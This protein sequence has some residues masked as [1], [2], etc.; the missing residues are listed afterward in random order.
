MNRIYFVFAFV[1][2]ALSSATVSA[3]NW[4][5]QTRQ[6]MGHVIVSDYD[7]ALGAAH[8]ALEA[9]KQELGPKH[10]NTARAMNNLGWVYLQLDRLEDARM[11]LDQAIQIW[12][13]SP[14]FEH[15]DLAIALDNLARCHKRLGNDLWMIHLNR[16]TLEERSLSDSESYDN[17]ERVPEISL[18][19]QILGEVEA[20]PFTVAVRKA[21]LKGDDKQYEVGIQMCDLAY[22][23]MKH[24]QYEYAEQLLNKSEEVLEQTLGPNDSRN[25]RTI[26][27]LAGIRGKSGDLAATEQ[28]YVKALNILEQ[29]PSKDIDQVVQVHWGL[30]DLFRLTGQS[31]LTDYISD[32][33][34]LVADIEAGRKPKTTPL[35][36]VEIKM[37]RA[38]GTSRFDEP[39]IQMLVADEYLRQAVSADLLRDYVLAES[40]YRV[41]L[42]LRT[43]ALGPKH[44]Q[45][46]ETHRRIADLYMAV[47]LYGLAEVHY[48]RALAIRETVMEPNNPNLGLIK[49]SLA[50]L[51]MV[52]SQV[53]RVP[54]EEQQHIE[55][56]AKE[57]AP[58]TDMNTTVKPTRRLS[59]WD[60]ETEAE[61]HR[62][63]AE[64]DK[65]FMAE[66]YIAAGV[67]ANRACWWAKHHVGPR[68]LDTALSYERIEQI[69]RAMGR[70][71][72]A[73]IYAK[74]AEKVRERVR[75]TN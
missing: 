37:I 47:G 25:V 62:L 57:H 51:H 60:S 11:V 15:A 14:D 69:L 21:I 75:D 55:L 31:E 46:A 34:Q 17:L 38:D 33:V 53:E 49:S 72:E 73:E 59:G 43:K 27:G 65:S 50:E 1:S 13:A 64:F 4:E 28:L 8:L 29:S 45:V 54:S 41:V 16:R 23:Y 32:R 10:P 58:K 18:S 20:E 19:T 26:L 5:D 44:P 61:W 9:A 68:H 3:R 30:R 7:S 71:K 36:Q 67:I 22:S 56:E 12:D 2:L 39:E 66:D 63:N 42:D 52:R 6:L 35:D 24:H 70:D 48:E 40:R 74:S